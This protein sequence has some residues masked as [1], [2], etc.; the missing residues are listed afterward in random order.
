MFGARMRGPEGAVAALEEEVLRARIG[1]LDVHRTRPLGEGTR[2]PLCLR[3]EELSMAV[4]D[5]T[6]GA[7]TACV[8]L[9]FVLPKGAFATTV[10]AAIFEVNDHEAETSGP[11]PASPE[12]TE[13]REDADERDADD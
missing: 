5:R 12:M 8:S 3:I 9:R 4:A 7:A 2:R 11:V 13:R 6:P 10:A 1:D